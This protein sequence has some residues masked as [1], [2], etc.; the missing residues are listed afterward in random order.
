LLKA[1]C[2][3]CILLLTNRVAAVVTSGVSHR[4]LRDVGEGSPNSEPVAALE[5]CDSRGCFSKAVCQG[6]ILLLTNRFAAVVTSGVSHRDLRDVG[7]GSP[8]SDL[9]R[10]WRYATAAD[11]FRK[12]FARDGFFY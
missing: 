3:G 5:L 4:D 8:T 2:Q 11:A 9:W 1:V 12:R 6:C 7:E 10:H